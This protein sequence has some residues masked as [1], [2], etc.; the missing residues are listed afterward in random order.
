MEK[1]FVYGTLKRNYSRNT[2]LLNGKFIGNRKTIAAYT[3]VDLGSFPGIL[4]QGT[5]TIFG[6]LY[7]VNKALL[8]TCDLIEGHPSFYI[9]KK[10]KLL[11]NENAWSYFLDF[12]KYK[13]YPKIK[14]GLWG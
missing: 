13:N 5:Q 10:I 14:S 2:V 1:L 11:N 6:E 8:K 12:E 7:F 4:N 9:R 3:M